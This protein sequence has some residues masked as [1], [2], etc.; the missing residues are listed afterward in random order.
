MN[1]DCRVRKKTRQVNEHREQRFTSQFIGCSLGV[2]G[3][4]ALSDALKQN[5]NIHKFFIWGEHDSISLKVW[6]KHN[7]HF[8]RM[9]EQETRLEMKEQWKFVILSNLIHHWIALMLSV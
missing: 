6:E 9:D 3:V 1:L 4:K 2:E 7:K 8:M 5:T